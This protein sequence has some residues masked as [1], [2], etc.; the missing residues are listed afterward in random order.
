[1]PSLLILYTLND[2]ELPPSAW[3]ERYLSIPR[4]V[5]EK[6]SRFRQWRDQQA[7]LLGKLLLLEGFKRWG[8]DLDLNAIFFDSYH[9]PF[10]HLPLD[11]NIA[12]AGKYVLAAFNPQGRIGIDVENIRPIYLADFQSVFTA[13]EIQAIQQ[14]PDGRRHF[15]SIWTRK[16][17]VIKAEGRG[18]SNQ[19]HLI[20]TL[21][22]PVVIENSSWFV[23]EVSLDTDHVCHFAT[24][25]NQAGL[26]VEILRIDFG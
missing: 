2:R 8:Y 3:L 18:L 9:R 23:Q 10:T 24:A 13:Q 25:A 20:S 11:F 12:H 19:L 14:H 22:N 1:M 15:F 4:E 7:G 21:E 16:E 17:A 5:Q 6:I 26:T